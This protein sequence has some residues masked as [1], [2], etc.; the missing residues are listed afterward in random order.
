MTDQDNALLTKSCT[1]SDLSQTFHTS[2]K[3]PTQRR[4]MYSSLKRSTT[5]ELPVK[6][7]INPNLSSPQVREMTKK[8]RYSTG[9]TKDISRELFNSKEFRQYEISPQ[10]QHKILERHSKLGHEALPFVIREKDKEIEYLRSQLFLFENQALQSAKLEGNIEALILENEKM[11]IQLKEKIKEITTLKARVLEL[12]KSQPSTIPQENPKLLEKF[13]EALLQKDKK[14]Q[15]LELEIKRLQEEIHQIQKGS[16][17]SRFKTEVEMYILQAD[18]KVEKV[19]HENEKLKQEV[20]NLKTSTN[21]VKTAELQEDL[22]RKEDTMEGYNILIKNI[23]KKMT[24]LSMKSKIS[25]GDLSVLVSEVEKEHKSLL[26]SGQLL[27]ERKEEES[28]D[29]YL[30]DDYCLW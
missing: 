5:T 25:T 17:P 14:I 19:S 29:P 20:K 16:I 2:K 23:I 12:K 28:S 26:T 15:E 30:I 9:V 21:A 8:N 7:N 3:S 6:E 10:T 4:L 1:E 11:D 22:K 13:S 18:S 24:S 27:E